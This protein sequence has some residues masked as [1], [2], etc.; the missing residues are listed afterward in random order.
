MIF[1][2]AELKAVFLL[3]TFLIV[4]PTELAAQN[5]EIRSLEIYTTDIRL[6]LPVVTKDNRLVIEFDVKSEFEPA[7]GILFRFCDYGWIPT[8]NI[9]L[10]N[11]YY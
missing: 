9:F 11:H 4:S 6:A 3:L 8:K 2:N 7:L 1:N 5:I 10:L